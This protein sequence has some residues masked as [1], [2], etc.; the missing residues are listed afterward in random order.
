MQCIRRSQ[1]R[2]N[3]EWMEDHTENTI[4]SEQQV[5]E[6]TNDQEQTEMKQST[7]MKQQ[8]EM[9]QQTVKKRVERENVTK[10]KY[11]RFSLQSSY[12]GVPLGDGVYLV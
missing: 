12:R 10:T 2:G 9:K 11:I 7:K 4:L 3:S 1:A 8:N 6:Q 5:E